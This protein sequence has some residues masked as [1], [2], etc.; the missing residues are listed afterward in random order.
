MQETGE[1]RQIIKVIYCLVYLLRYGIMIALIS[2][3]NQ[4]QNRKAK[5]H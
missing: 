1:N 5:K 2:A 4:N 3:T